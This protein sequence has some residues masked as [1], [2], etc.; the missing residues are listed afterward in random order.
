MDI[1]SL[2]QLKLSDLNDLRPR[3]LSELWISKPND[4]VLVMSDA[5]LSLEQF[6]LNGVAGLVWKFCDGQ[7]S[8]DDIANEIAYV[9]KDSTPNKAV[10][11]C[12]IVEFLNAIHDQGLILL[13]CVRS[14]DVLL[15]VPPAPNV[16][17]KEAVNTPEYSSPPLGICYIA[18]VLQQH[19]IG[20]AIA[21]L[22]QGQNRP[23]DVVSCCRNMNP[24]IVGITASTP[25]YPNALRVSRFVKAWNPDVVIVLGGPHATGSADA[26]AHAASFDFVCVGEGEQSFVELVQA[27]LNGKTDPRRVVGFV[28]Q[29]AG[30]IIRTGIPYRLENLDSLPLPAR[31]LLNLD[32]YYQKGAIISS[33]GC[34]IGCNFCSCAAIVGNTYRVHSVGRVLDEM[35]ILKDRHGLR[36]FDFHDDTFNLYSNR[37]FDFC[38]QLRERMLG[39]EWGCFCRAAQM[40]PDMAKAMAQAGCRVIQFGVEAGSDESLRKLHKQT[41][42]RQVEDGV[43]WAREA[44]IDQVV[45]GFIIGHAH[46]TEADVRA[47]IDL[48]LK[49]AKMGATRLTLSLL[50]PYPGTEIYDQRQKFG[51]DLICDDWEQYTFSRVVM[52][53]KHLKRDRLRE[54]YVEGLQRFLD[55]TTR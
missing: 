27:L 14:L 30:Q 8:V 9:C 1:P 45:C 5:R 4:S 36:F 39:V 48:G 6:H 49:L 37:V 7:H 52:E 24:K 40:T 47:T 20:V 28:H 35:Q 43:R 38:R 55:V 50:T 41:L 22:H 10:L 3:R 11:V 18:A 54:L 23:E 25:S 26:C 53:T 16:F 13:D 19:G 46:D 2:K 15:V 34:P 42:V 12:E 21:D 44:G 29:E 32:S 17:V 33:R 31:D 51:I